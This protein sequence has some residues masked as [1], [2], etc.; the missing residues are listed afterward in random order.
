MESAHS[1]LPF[2]HEIILFLA[3]AALVVPLLS[4]IGINSIISYLLCGVALGPYGITLFAE[5]APWLKH[6]V[7]PD[8]QTVKPIAELGVIF[9]LF[10]IGLEVSPQRLWQMRKLVFGLGTSQVVVTGVVIGTIAYLWGN[11]PVASVLLGSSLALSS[12]A[13]VVQLLQDKRLLNTPM[14]QSSLSVLLLQDLAVIPILFMLSVFI[15]NT[16]GNIWQ[17][18][19]MALLQAAA[20]MVLI[21]FVA[22]KLLRPLFSF[23][24]GFHSDDMFIALTL[25][26]I[27]GTAAFAQA[28]HVS[29]AM[30]AFIAGLVLAESEFRHKIAHHIEPFKGLL[31]GLFF[32]SF[33]MTINIWA[34]VNKPVWIVLSVIGMVGIKTLITTL[35]ARLHGVRL[36]VALESGLILGQA[37]EF[38]LLVIGAS[39]A[40]GI[41]APDIAQF[42]LIVVGLS[43]F[44][45]PP[46]AVAARRLGLWLEQRA[47]VDHEALRAHNEPATL[48]GHVIIMGY[49]RAGQMIANTL[50]GEGVS[51]VVLDADS[52]KVT[53]AYQEGIPIHYGDVEEPE[54]LLEMG[55]ERASALIVAIDDMKAADYVVAHVRKSWPHLPVV[56]RTQDTDQATRWAGEEMVQ[57]VPETLE[58]SL[59]MAF[60]ALQ[61]LGYSSE[62]ARYTTTAHRRNT[63]TYVDEEKLS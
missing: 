47:Q 3:V 17:A 58:V 42:M 59:Q 62:E 52:R 26:V 11:T 16:E 29:M 21:Y 45:T 49:G 63:L 31:L 9:L 40:G 37:G 48:E 36:P 53:K 7:I 56:L 25:L 60:Y 46:L 28:A 27:I 12:T 55:V 44:V 32:L 39:M 24:G 30:G 1:T 2:L 54:H 13:I 14:G 34:F 4:K 10:M 51:Y 57:A 8:P 20:V 33:G 6:F 5:S 35:L 23:I 43:M 15:G 22:R 50:A 38:G 41:I 61:R 19:G 18:L